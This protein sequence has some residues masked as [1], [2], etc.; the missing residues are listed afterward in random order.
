[1]PPQLS[2][3]N[4]QDSSCRL[5]E[6]RVLSILYRDPIKEKREC[7]LPS[8]QRSNRRKENSECYWSASA[9][10]APPSS[11]VLKQ[12][13]KILPNRAAVLRRWPLCGSAHEHIIASLRS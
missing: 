13:S 5:V 1:M 10:S 2:A 3:N 4:A 6:R 8:K 7:L 9:P 12:S 11:P